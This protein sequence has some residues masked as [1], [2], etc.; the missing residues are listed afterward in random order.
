MQA[1][2]KA[3]RTNDSQGRSRYLG[4]SFGISLACL[5][6]ACAAD[7]TAAGG[8]DRTRNVDRLYFMPL[9]QPGLLLAFE[10]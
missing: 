9:N 6:F 3:G 5:L 1:S 4:H 8:T 7:A 10:E 2:F